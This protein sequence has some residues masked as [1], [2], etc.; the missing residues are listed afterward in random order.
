MS[1][2]PDVVVAIQGCIQKLRD[3]INKAIADHGLEALE[4]PQG[5][6][7]LENRLQVLFAFVTDVY[8]DELRCLYDMYDHIIATQEGIELEN[9][10]PDHNPADYGAN[11]QDAL[12]CLQD[13]SKLEGAEGI[14]CDQY[15]RCC[16]CIEDYTTEHPAFLIK[17]CGHILGEPCFET[18]VNGTQPNANLCPVC[19]A[20]LCDRRPRRPRRGQVEEQDRLEHRLETQVSP[21]YGHL[22]K[23]H[24]L[25]HGSE[26]P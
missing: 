16:V 24:Q 15:H 26:T 9:I 10:G 22:R 7:N 3:D 14:D 25:L 4:G 8:V 12:P 18:W 21:L 19:R 11:V 5:M 2:N 23:L 6:A 17:N 13:V 1:E 20:Q